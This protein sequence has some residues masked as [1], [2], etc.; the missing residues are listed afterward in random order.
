MSLIIQQYCKWGNQ[1]NFRLLYSK[2]S[3]QKSTKRLQK[4]KIKIVLKNI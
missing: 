4:I 3:A 2:I 1:D